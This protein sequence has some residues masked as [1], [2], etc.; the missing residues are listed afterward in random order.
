MTISAKNEYCENTKIYQSFIEIVDFRKDPKFPL[1]MLSVQVCKAW[2]KLII[3]E[4]LV[5]WHPS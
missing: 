1:M 5:I 4:D 3:P 2:V